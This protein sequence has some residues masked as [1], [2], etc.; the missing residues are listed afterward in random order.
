MVWHSVS[1]LLFPTQHTHTTLPQRQH[2]GTK[3]W[4]FNKT[5][6]QRSHLIP[7]WILKRRERKAWTRHQQ[8]ESLPSIPSPSILPSLPPSP[9]VKRK[10][11]SMPGTVKDTPRFKGISEALLS[12]KAAAVF[13]SGQRR[14]DNKRS[15]RRDSGC[16]GKP[17]PQHCGALLLSK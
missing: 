8:C 16:M 11:W 9:L 3:H 1:K 2:F 7:A 13:L 12:H 15:Q 4:P 6:P 10:N 17:L 5:G 14:R